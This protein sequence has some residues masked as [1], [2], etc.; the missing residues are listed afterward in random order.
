MPP[1]RALPPTRAELALALVLAVVLALVLSVVLWSTGVGTGV[2]TGAV[3][4]AKGRRW[5]DVGAA[6][7]FGA[8]L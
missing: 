3:Q 2:G 1:T 8:G 4:A 5:L 6:G 7:N